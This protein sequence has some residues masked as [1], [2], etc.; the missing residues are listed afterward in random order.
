MRTRESISAEA[1][2]TLARTHD[3]SVV[4]LI[5][6]DRA[7]FPHIHEDGITEPDPID[8]EGFHWVL[9]T[10][11]KPIGVFLLHAHGAIC[12]E[13]HV[14]LLPAAWG[15][16]ARLAAEKLKQYIFGDLKAQK[17]IVRVPAY[18]R[19]A[20]QFAKASGMQI[21][22]VNRASFLR[23]GE[24]IDQVML[25]ITLKEWTCQQQQSQQ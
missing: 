5:L 3:M 20:V 1:G 7:I 2:I 8:H 11:D 10:A 12:W 6:A 4:R 18:N 25:G 13:V 9:V 21:E 22:G 17:I 16:R 24:A 23:G 15:K 14:C 19:R